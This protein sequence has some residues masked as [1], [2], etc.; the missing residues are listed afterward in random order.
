V[1]AEARRVMS[2]TRCRSL[3]LRG[4]PDTVEGAYVFRQGLP[5]ALASLPTTADGAAC[6]GQWHAGTVVVGAPGS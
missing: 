1:L 5:E 6:T 3:E 2:D 4:A